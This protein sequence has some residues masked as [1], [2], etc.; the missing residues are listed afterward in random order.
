[1]LKMLD[2]WAKLFKGQ[3]ASSTFHSLENYKR[4]IV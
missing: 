2:Y 3:L 1:M 4:L